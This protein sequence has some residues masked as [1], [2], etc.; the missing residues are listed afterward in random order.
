MYVSE[1][2][3]L[4]LAG[5]RAA[6]TR[7]YEGHRGCIYYLSLK[8]TGSR[9]SAEEMLQYSFLHAF[10][11]LGLLKNPDSLRDWLL[12][13]ASNRSKNLLRSKNP[14]L[15]QD[16]RPKKEQRSKYVLP[17]NSPISKI[18]SQNEARTAVS[19]AVSALPDALR[20]AVML[21]FYCGMPLA[22]TAKILEC[23]ENTVKIYL[24][25]AEQ[26]LMKAVEAKA[27][28]LPILKEYSGARELNAIFERE[29]EEIMVPEYLTES[30]V[31]AAA[32]IAESSDRPAGNRT[33]EFYNQP[34][35][36]N[37]RYTLLIS[38]LVILLAAVI[39]IGAAVAISQHGKNPPSDDNPAQN[40]MSDDST[41]DFTNDPVT[42]PVTDPPT[43]PITDPITDPVT[44]PVT[45]PVTE[46]IETDPPLPPETEPPVTD[47]PASSFSASAAGNE[48]SITAYIGSDPVVVIP[49]EIDG[50]PVTA[51]G[52]GAF[53]GSTVQSVTIPSSVKTI[54]TNAFKDCTMLNT[55]IISEGVT[56]IRDY[57]FMGCTSLSN[58]SL[59]SSIRKVGSTILGGSGWWND[60]AAGFLSIGDG[61]L[62]RYT[63]KDGAVTVP[64]GI[65]IISNAFYYLGTVKN[66]VIPEGVTSVGTFAFCACPK[67]TSIV[68]PKSVSS[69]ADNAIY[70]CSSLTE[71]YVSE[72]SYAHQWCLDN[73]F[74]SFIK[75]Y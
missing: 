18:A 24:T 35:H 55:L 38:V 1:I 66:I 45:E 15:F 13:V 74:A 59:P 72:N 44:D 62:L 64:D 34:R 16:S 22:K 56:E 10:N 61:I 17:E 71:I 8:L 52:T 47:T 7:L 42:D 43:D 32:A 28:S 70:E 19:D 30:I 75:L 53:M 20:F 39:V 3:P 9:E 63:G 2:I 41:P 26:R 33:A 67:L 23:S 50:K 37:N 36:T 11:K 27:A 73:G 65:K 5:D 40:D 49:S 60:Q 58:V 4:A 46:P 25:E 69:I 6:I 48:V 68:F 54:G 14:A 12:A 29:A 51:I 21:T 57:A 31:A